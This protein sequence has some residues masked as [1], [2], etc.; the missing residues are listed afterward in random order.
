MLQGGHEKVNGQTDRRTDGQTDRQTG[1]IQY[2]PPNFVAGGITN[3]REIA[4]NYGSA[5]RQL[6]QWGWV[7]HICVSKLTI[8]DSDNGLSPGR[9]QAIIWTYAGIFVNWTLR[10]KFQWNWN[11]N[12]YIVIQE[13]AFENVV[14]KMVAILSRPQCVKEL[15]WKDL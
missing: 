14:R 12:S 1:W 15:I 10:N 13:N 7:T 4:N 8:T 11:R 2:T 9:R 3:I 5:R 6:T